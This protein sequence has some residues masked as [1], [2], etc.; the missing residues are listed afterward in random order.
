MLR[1]TNVQYQMYMSPRMESCLCSMTQVLSF[2]MNVRG[3]VVDCWGYLVLARTTNSTGEG[4][5]STMIMYADRSL[6]EIKERN[7][8][9]DDGMQHVRTTK[10]PI[11]PIPL[12]TETVELLMRVC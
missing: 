6:G 2:T 1:L 9:G 8:F 11:Q 12:F 5:G 4:V 3:V 10:E 7:W